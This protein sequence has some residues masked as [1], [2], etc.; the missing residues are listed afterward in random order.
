VRRARPLGLLLALAAQWPHVKNLGAHHSLHN[1]G[2]MQ[3]V[4]LDR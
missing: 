1:Y 2:R 4:W 3:E